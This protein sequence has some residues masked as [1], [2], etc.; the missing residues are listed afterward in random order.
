MKKFPKAKKIITTLRGSINA[1]NNLWSGVLYD[2]EKAFFSKTHNITHI[3]DRVGGGDSFMAGL[4]Y[5]LRVLKDDQD[6]LEFAAAASSLKHTIKGDFNL[7][8]IDE[9]N[10]ILSGDTSGRVSR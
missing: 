1:S 4:I 9:V 7:V 5:G 3:V 6:A 2:G 10:R 8:T